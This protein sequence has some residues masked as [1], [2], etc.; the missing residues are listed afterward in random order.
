M[1][2]SSSS[3]TSSKKNEG[4]DGVIC[5][6]LFGSN[7]LFFLC[8]LHLGKQL[9]TCSMRNACTRMGHSLKRERRF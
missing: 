4:R 5:S 7:M 2:K 8:A 1:N 9:S 3:K 6:L